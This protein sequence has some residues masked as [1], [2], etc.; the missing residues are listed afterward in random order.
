[1]GFLDKLSEKI[2]DVGYKVVD[3]SKEISDVSKLNGYI[4]E[5][6]KKLNGLYTQIGALYCQLHKDDFEAAFGELM[7]PAFECQTKIEDYREQIRKT[8]GLALCV[9]CGAQLN[10]DF[11][12]CSECGEPIPAEEPTVPDVPVSNVPVSG[13]RYCVGCG[14]ALQDGTFFCTN[15]GMPVSND[16]APEIKAPPMGE[17]VSAPASAASYSVKTEPAYGGVIDPMP[18]GSFGVKTEPAG[19]NAAPVAEAPGFSMKTEPAPF[20]ASTGEMKTCSRCGSVMTPDKT[21]CT[22]CGSRL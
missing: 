6:E 17:T 21:F 3:K 4:S 10:R 8:K 22:D 12:F 11:A 20:V 2:S 5:E 9:K 14:A 18:S 19:Y 7:T 13:G 16:S 15:C 1:M